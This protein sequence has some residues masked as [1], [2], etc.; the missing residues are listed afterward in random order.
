MMEFLLFLLLG[1][2]VF[3]PVTGNARI[4]TMVVYAVL[5]VLLLFGV[6]SGFNLSQ[7]FH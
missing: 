6:G 1:F 2:A 4:I 7:H 5:M 3:I